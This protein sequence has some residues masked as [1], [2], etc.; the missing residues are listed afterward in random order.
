MII[1]AISSA[2]NS[3]AMM[4]SQ[5]SADLSLRFLLTR[6]RVSSLEFQKESHMS[7]TEYLTRLQ[8]HG[9]GDATRLLEFSKKRA[10]RAA[11]IL[12]PP[13]SFPACQ[14]R[15]LSR[16]IGFLRHRNGAS[17]HSPERD[18]RYRIAHDE[19]HALA[20][21]RSVHPSDDDFRCHC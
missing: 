9:R 1:A 6:N 4:R 5:S 20:V 10:V 13:L 17:R 15:M 7:D 19:T 16:G 11:E 12:D 18:L 2:F 21:P 3:R 8:K 14:P